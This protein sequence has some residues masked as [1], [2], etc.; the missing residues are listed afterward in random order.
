VKPHPSPSFLVLWI[1]R[2][3]AGGSAYIGVVALYAVSEVGSDQLV[4]QISVGLLGLMGGLLFLFGLERP[5]HPL[6]RL[7]RTVG[8]VMT[9]GFAVFPSMV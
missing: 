8:W 9:A 1:G 4:M 6:S 2:V 5:A 7:A 3:V